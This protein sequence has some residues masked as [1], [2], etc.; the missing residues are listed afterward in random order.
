MKYI[1]V[2]SLP[3]KKVISALAN[4]FNTERIKNCDEHTLHLPE[5][6]G[7]GTIKGINFHSGLGILQYEVNFLEDTEIQFVV[8]EVHPLKFLFSITGTIEHRFKGDD[9]ANL[10]HQYQNAIVAS[11][12]HNGH[13]LTFKKN[14]IWP[15]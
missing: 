6:I 2:H 11:S 12:N 1:Q 3:L 10:I 9:N 5:H 8:D 7:T 15:L 4:F 14:K 13:I